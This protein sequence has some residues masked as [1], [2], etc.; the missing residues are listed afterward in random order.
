MWCKWTLASGNGNSIWLMS[1]FFQIRSGMIMAWTRIQFLTHSSI[2]FLSGIAPFQHEMSIKGSLS[3]NYRLTSLKKH[4]SC[5]RLVCTC[6][7]HDYNWLYAKRKMVCH[8]L[9]GATIAICPSS[10]VPYRLQF[11]M[12]EIFLP[13]PIW[14]QYGNSVV[15]LCW[16]YQFLLDHQN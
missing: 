13:H 3:S 16:K 4:F 6:A 8:L 9:D 15:H 11:K 1:F 7:S 5:K 12:W 2:N 14:Y 10:L